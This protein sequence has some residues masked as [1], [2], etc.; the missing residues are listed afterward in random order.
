[1]AGG[2]LGSVLWSTRK[3]RNTHEMRSQVGEKGEKRLKGSI[4]PFSAASL[5]ENLFPR[6]LGGCP[7]H[8]LL[9]FM[10]GNTLLILVSCAQCSFH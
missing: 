5:V 7:V 9:S 8:L 4:C 10:A 1:M 2:S 3:I 6:G